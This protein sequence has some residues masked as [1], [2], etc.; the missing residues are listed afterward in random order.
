MHVNRFADTKAPFSRAAQNFDS[1]RGNALGN[2]LPTEA[3]NIHRMAVPIQD[4]P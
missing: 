2:I 3:A 4:Y 1:E